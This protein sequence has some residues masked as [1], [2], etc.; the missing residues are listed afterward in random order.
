M[1]NTGVLGGS[2]VG[3]QGTWCVDQTLA[4]RILVLVYDCPKLD[5]PSTGFWFMALGITE[6]L[7]PVSWGSQEGLDP[8]LSCYML[9]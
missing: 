4:L 8:D 7:L 5:F 2:D 3:W 6:T 9:G 1:Q